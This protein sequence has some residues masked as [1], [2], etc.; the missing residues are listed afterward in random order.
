MEEISGVQF[1]GLPVEELLFAFA[2]GMYWS[3]VYEHFT[4]RRL[5]AHG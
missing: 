4:W 1:F 5:Q 3:G 2:F